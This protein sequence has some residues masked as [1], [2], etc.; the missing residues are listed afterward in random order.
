MVLLAYISGRYSFTAQTLDSKGKGR[1][2]IP[3]IVAV[4]FM[5]LSRAR[6]TDQSIISR[7]CFSTNDAPKS[8]KRLLKHNQKRSVGGSSTLQDPWRSQVHFLEMISMRWSPFAIDWEE[9][10]A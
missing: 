10:C 8:Q 9:I 3:S 6:T 1:C 4:E 2:E 7:H 5:I